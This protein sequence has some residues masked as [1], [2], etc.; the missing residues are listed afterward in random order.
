MTNIEVFIEIIKKSHPIALKNVL[1]ACTI[2]YE[3]YAGDELIRITMAGTGTTYNS[4]THVPFPP[5]A[6]KVV[7][8]AWDGTRTTTYQK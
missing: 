3:T 5:N 1:K 7:A 2:V 6:T 8:V 4:S